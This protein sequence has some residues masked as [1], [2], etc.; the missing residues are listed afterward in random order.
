[1]GSFAILRTIESCGLS[2]TRLD[3]CLL[4]IKTSKGDTTPV[5]VYPCGGEAATVAELPWL[6]SSHP[7]P[8]LHSAGP[9]G[10]TQ[11]SHLPLRL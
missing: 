1:M 4:E 8:L 9:V 10:G 3:S 5:A 6:Q 7:F 11:G 2:P